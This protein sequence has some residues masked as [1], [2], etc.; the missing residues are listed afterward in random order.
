MAIAFITFSKVSQ[1]NVRSN[2]LEA[3]ARSPLTLQA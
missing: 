2:A 3:G 1:K